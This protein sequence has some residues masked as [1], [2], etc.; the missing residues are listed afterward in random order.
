MAA[1]YFAALTGEQFAALTTYRA[2]GAPVPTAVWFAAVA[3]RLYVRT[4]ATSGK[5]KRL[6]AN[7]RVQ[8]A[9]CTMDGTITGP[10]IDAQ[11]QIVD[12]AAPD[13]QVG[14]AALDAKYG[15]KRRANTADLQTRQIPLALI[16]ITPP[17]K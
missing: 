12:P 15:D 2:S 3:D 4:V 16:V 14:E 1:S 5:V 11:A 17:E 7:G 10:V 6:R 9:P 8:V 13:W